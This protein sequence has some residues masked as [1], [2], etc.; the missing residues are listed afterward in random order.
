MLPIEHIGPQLHST[1]AG[2]WQGWV[3]QMS[4]AYSM[5]VRSEEKKPLPAVDM[6]DMRVHLA[7]S[8]YVSSMRSC[9]H[10]AETWSISGYMSSSAPTTSGLI[11]NAASTDVHAAKL[12]IHRSRI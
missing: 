2:T 10:G 8:L 4:R 9:T 12:N 11:W 1:G 6:M 7:L 3:F 5:M